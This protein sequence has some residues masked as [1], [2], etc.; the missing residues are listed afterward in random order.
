MV[1][2]HRSYIYIY[3]LIGSIEMTN[4]QITLIMQQLHLSFLKSEF[5]GTF[6]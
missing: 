4:Y 2:A 6:G 1:T 3:M 5:V